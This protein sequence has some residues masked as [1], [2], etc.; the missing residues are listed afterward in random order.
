VGGRWLGVQVGGF[1]CADDNGL[2]CGV[3]SPD[4]WEEMGEGA[5]VLPGLYSNTLTFSAGPRVRGARVMLKLIRVNWFTVVYGDAVLTGRDQD[6]SV[7]FT[8]E[9]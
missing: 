9:L 8:D 2:M 7:H 5:S 1:L 6:V 4:R 3:D